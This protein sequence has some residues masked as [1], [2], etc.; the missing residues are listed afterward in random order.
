MHVSQSTEFYHVENGI[1]IT[2][3]L[4]YHSFLLLLFISQIKSVYSITLMTCLMMSVF[5]TGA[6]SFSPSSVIFTHLQE[7]KLSK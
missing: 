7:L 1:H 2:V 4:S 5:K 3:T 6:V